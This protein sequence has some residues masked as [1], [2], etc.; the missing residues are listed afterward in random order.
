MK[1]ETEIPDYKKA[2]LKQIQ[3]E[4]NRLELAILDSV[5][6]DNWSVEPKKGYFTSRNEEYSE[7]VS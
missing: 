4:I 6:M 3:A 5:T 7:K 2:S 1:K